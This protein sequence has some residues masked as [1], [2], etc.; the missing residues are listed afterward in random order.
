MLQ[1]VLGSFFSRRIPSV[2]AMG[3]KSYKRDLVSSSQED[4][5]EA[6]K[7]ERE[8]EEGF[9]FEFFKPATYILECCTSRDVVDYERSDGSSIVS[10][11]HGTEPFLACCVPDLCLHFFALDL[12]A[13]RLKLYADGGFGIV[14]EL[15]SR[16]SGEQIGLPHRGVADQHHL[17]EVIF[18]LV[19]VMRR[20]S[21]S[22]LL[23]I[24]FRS[25]DRDRDRDRDRESPCNG[26]KKLRYP[27]PKP[28]CKGSPN[29]L[30]KAASKRLTHSLSRWIFHSCIAAKNNKRG[31]KTV[32]SL[33][34]HSKNSTTHTPATT[35][36]QQHSRTWRHRPRQG[37]GFRVELG[38]ERER[39]EGLRDF[40]CCT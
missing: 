35:D 16:V 26:R 39:E 17:E 29:P 6:R 2:S 3:G 34:L 18:D 20:H 15:V 13:L 14:V 31:E 25:S 37:L 30:P 11:S 28:S 10:G 7:R 4:E 38:T 19:I 21:S 9:T 27:Q 12:H 40:C 8:M 1:E 5:E 22:F 36:L 32:S 23:R 33:Q 24:F